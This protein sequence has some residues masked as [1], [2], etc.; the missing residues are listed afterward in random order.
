MK[1]ILTK[2]SIFISR[3]FWNYYLHPCQKAYAIEL[4]KCSKDEIIWID[5]PTRNPLTW[6]KSMKFKDPS[7][8]SVYRPFAVNREYECFSILDRILFWVQ[9]VFII[10]VKKKPNLWSIACPHPWLVKSKFF[11]FTI[12]WPGDFFEPKSEYC[13]YKNYDLVMS[14]TNKGVEQIP[15]HFKGY[16]FKTSTCPG[17]AF[18]FHDKNVKERS[19]FASKEVTFTK[20]YIIYLGGLSSRRVDFEILEFLAQELPSYS[21]ILAAKPD[22]LRETLSKIEKLLKHG[23]VRLLDNLQY[24]D[25]PSIVSAAHVGIVPYLVNYDNSGIC[26]NKIFEYASLT[27][28]IVSTAIP[29]VLDYSP[30]VMIAKNKDMFLSM[31]KE[32]LTEPKS[33]ELT[34]E[35]KIMSKESTP[36]S[37]I[38]GIQNLI[39]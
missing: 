30:P 23:N 19:N 4:A 17:D 15:N 1:N 33:E 28:P 5:P 24:E 2:C 34:R 38:E 6:L 10:P 13:L 9:L 32:Y 39:S 21:L 8:V 7:G 3:N 20:P 31:S 29:A 26:P 16:S 25:L 14:W 27:V 22:G 18:I 35:L 11:S 37:N 36:S 12:Y